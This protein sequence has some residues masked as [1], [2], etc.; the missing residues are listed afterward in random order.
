MAPKRQR[1]DGSGSRAPRQFDTTNFVSAAI[2]ERF[3]S[4][5]VN[6]TLVLERGIMPQEYSDRGIIATIEERGWETLTA[7]PEATAVAIV[8]EFYANATEARNNVV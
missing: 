4:L 1:G 2:S 6:K 7:Q 8:K 5:L 3:H